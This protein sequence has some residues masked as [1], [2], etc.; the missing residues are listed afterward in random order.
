MTKKTKTI[1]K[2]SSSVIA[3][4]T[5]LSV[6]MGQAFEPNIN[7]MNVARGNAEFK[8]KPLGEIGSYGVPMVGG[9]P[10][11]DFLTNLMGSNGID[12]YTEMRENDSIIGAIIQTI[13]TLFRRIPFIIDTNKEYIG[14]PE[15]EA[16]RDFIEDV[17]F[18]DMDIEFDDFI[19]DAL[20][21]WVYGYSLFEKVYKIR[22]D[23]KIGLRKIAFRPQNTKYK[24]DIANNGDI[25][26][27]EQEDPNN[28]AL[29]T[30]PY[31]KCVHFT[32]VYNKGNPDGRSLLRNAYTSW[33]YAKRLQ[34]LEAVGYE[35]DL[36]GTPIMKVPA[37]LLGSTDPKD[38][39]A[40][41]AYTRLV[42]DL[43]NNE[44]AGAVI[45]SDTYL[46]DDGSV[47]SV[48]KVELSLLA[49]SSGRSNDMSSPI[50]RYHADMARALMADYIMLGT[51]E[52]GSYSLAESKKDIFIATQEYWVEKVTTVISKQIIKDLMT[53]NGID[54]KY[55]PTIRA[56]SVY[57][58]SIDTL[59]SILQRLG[60]SG[61]PLY[62]DTDLE[63]HVR[64]QLATLMPKDIK[65]IEEARK[66]PI[67]EKFVDSKP[68]EVKPTNV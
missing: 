47:S 37:Q 3:N 5:P 48:A 23:G 26:A 20:S 36:K 28:G 33:Y 16:A 44:Q 17:L 55:T 29:Y 41:Q 58:L 35:R 62:P 8:S 11:D 15:A 21:M 43:R 68:N 2:V 10:R 63:N 42:R 52:R 64:E 12:T 22:E 46:N 40:V 1:K 50:N 4:V 67:E 34:E 56:G 9:I 24:W 57:P 30:I 51:Q 53:I 61:F 65:E 7:E 25:L 6:G 45:P 39:Q 54:K 13:E 49:D 27:F 18:E 38:I 59:A 19:S 60:Q 14:V 66:P 31:S 32:T